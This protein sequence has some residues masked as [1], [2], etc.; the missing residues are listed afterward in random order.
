MTGIDS[1]GGLRLLVAVGF[2]AGHLPVCRRVWAARGTPATTPRLK[3]ERME[4]QAFA[5]FLMVAVL[6]VGVAFGGFN[7]LG[8]GLA[9]G[10]AARA[11]VGLYAHIRLKFL[12]G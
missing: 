7:H 6:A 1:V 8:V 12:G 3:Y 5:A 10:A 2:L 4:I 9:V 11:V